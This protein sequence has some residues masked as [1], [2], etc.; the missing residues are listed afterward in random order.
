MDN[1]MYEAPDCEVILVQMGSG[2]LQSSP[3]SV[4]AS[5][6]GYGAANVETWE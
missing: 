4:K 6:D 3:D 1:K 2:L 5:R